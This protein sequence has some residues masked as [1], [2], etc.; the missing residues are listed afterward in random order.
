MSTQN[1]RQ[2]KGIRHC[3]TLERIGRQRATERAWAASPHPNPVPLRRPA[4]AGL[5][6]RISAWWHAI[7]SHS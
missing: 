2:R 7:G 4:R 3:Q 6:A 1:L 5:A